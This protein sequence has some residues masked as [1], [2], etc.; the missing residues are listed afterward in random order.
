MVTIDV[1][2]IGENKIWIKMGEKMLTIIL[3]LRVATNRQFI[4]NITSVK[5]N[6]AKHNKTRWACKKTNV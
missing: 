6:K 3:Q 1:M 2:G 5:C 4:K